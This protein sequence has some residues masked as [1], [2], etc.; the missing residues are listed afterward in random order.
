LADIFSKK[1]RSDIMSKIKGKNTEPE[2]VVR[3]LLHRMGYRFRI[4]RADLPGKPDIVL[5]KYK[6]VIFV[7]GCF[8]HHHRDCKYA[9]EP[10]TRAEFWKN[11]FKKNAERDQK[12]KTELSKMGWRVGV[13]WEC[14]TRDKN[15]LSCRLRS[16]LSRFH[17]S[18]K[19]DCNF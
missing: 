15:M 17:S 8:W 10:K 14:E 1:I 13:V 5:S 3:S 18:L 9:Y 11:K 6:V 16:L 19:S 2:R 4:H 12:I 7:H